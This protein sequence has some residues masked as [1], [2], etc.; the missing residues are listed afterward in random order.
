LPLCSSVLKLLATD[1]CNQ[2]VVLIFCENLEYGY[3]MLCSFINYGSKKTRFLLQRI[4]FQEHKVLE[5]LFRHP[6]N[7]VTKYNLLQIE[8]LKKQKSDDWKLSRC[9]QYKTAHSNRH[10]HRQSTF[11]QPPLKGLVRSN[12]HTRNHYLHP[13]LSSQQHDDGC[14]NTIPAFGNPRRICSPSSRAGNCRAASRIHRY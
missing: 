14:S 4:P 9:W 1:D 6:S 2:I 11:A 13:R 3:I 12:V 7:V 8:H 5:I 10:I